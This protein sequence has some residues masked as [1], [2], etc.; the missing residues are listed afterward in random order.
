MA[1]EFSNILTIVIA[2]AD[3]LAEAL[4]PDAPQMSTD[5][6]GLRR[7]ARRGADITDTM[8]AVVR[9][10]RLVL[11][12]LDVASL[13]EATAPTLERLLPE[14]MELVIDPGKA[15]HHRVR[16]DA[17][18]L[19]QILL[20]LVL[21]ARDAMPG[22]GRVTLALETA[23]IRGGDQGTDEIH[24]LRATH[25]ADGSDGLEGGRLALVVSDTG[26]GIAPELRDQVFEP[27]FTT[28]A[29]GRG[30][31]LGLALVR[32]L[33][34]Q[35]GGVVGVETG[36]GGGAA[37]R[38]E[39]AV[40]PPAAPSA[41]K[42]DAPEAE[43]QGRPGAHPEGPRRILIA[44]DEEVIRRSATRVLERYGYTV[45]QAADG[46]EALQRLEER[47]D[48]VDLV[49][50]DIVMPR[51]DGLGL[52]RA[53]RKRGC[54]CPF[55]FT[56]GYQN[57]DVWSAVDDDPSLDFLPKPW[58]V[59]ELLARVGAMLERSGRRSPGETQGPS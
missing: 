16:A 51:L 42:G 4:P 54:E 28:K 11:R 57:E 26:P 36:P 40:V 12:P 10:Q 55:L 31:G 38:V 3:L 53:V 15:A 27:F 35:H 2:K 48:G 56:S 17:G 19:Q 41:P 9:P 52:L 34:G 25:G 45:L 5:L 14:G 43:G 1:H 18:A 13:L 20:N 6:E 21:N 33:V 24:G 32:A 46:V 59:P 8:L 39:L 23:E 50:S 29:P 49:V 44:E 58:S 30:V 37:V 7:A 47:P 22:G